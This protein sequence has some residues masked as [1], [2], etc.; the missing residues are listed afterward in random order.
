MAKNKAAAPT[1][2]DSV[3]WGFFLILTVVMC[4]P[5]IAVAWLISYESTE[6]YTRV[7]MGI[8]FSAVASA[9]LTWI[10]NSALQ[11]RVERLKKAQRKRGGKRK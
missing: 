6:W 8:M 4:I 7:G 10:V 11:Y 2:F 9:I 5:G 3:G 1:R